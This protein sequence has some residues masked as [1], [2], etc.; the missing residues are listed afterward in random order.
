MKPNIGCGKIDMLWMAL[1][2]IIEV[3][4]AAWDETEK[5]VPL[6]SFSFH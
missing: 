5:L 4:T 2:A 6:V 3:E 1:V